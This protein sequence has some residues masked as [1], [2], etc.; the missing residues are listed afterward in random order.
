MIAYEAV[1]TPTGARVFR[2]VDEDREPLRQRI[3][4]HS[5]TGFEW[6]YAGSGPA[7]L[8][9]NIL[10]DAAGDDECTVHGA[11]RHD[12]DPFCWV[13]NEYATAGDGD[14]TVDVECS[15]GTARWVWELHQRFKFDVVA[16]ADRAGFRITQD[17][18]LAWVA[19]QGV[20]VGPVA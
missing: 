9:L 6:G 8:A 13:A 12:A 11:P 14:L 18:V 10:A 3:V 2:V 16:C 17:E 7:D 4:Y 1:R 20:E 15:F 5:P 19:A